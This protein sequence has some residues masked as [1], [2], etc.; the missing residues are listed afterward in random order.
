MRALATAREG[1]VTIA[2][3][4]CSRPTADRRIDRKRVRVSQMAPGAPNRVASQGSPGVARQTATTT[5]APTSR[6]PVRST[7]CRRRRTSSTLAPYAF[8]ASGSKLMSR[9]SIS[10]AATAARSRFLCRDTPASHTGHLVLCQTINAGLLTIATLQA[11]FS[12]AN[13]P[14]HRRVERNV[15]ARARPREI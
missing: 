11:K 14:A 1:F 15:A 12:S 4:A 7:A 3:R 6:A 2:P 8:S 5:S 13:A 9:N 10:P